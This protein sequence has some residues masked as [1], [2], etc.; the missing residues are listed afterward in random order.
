M[1]GDT[2]NMYD[3]QHNTGIVHNHAPAPALTPEQAEALAVVRS[4]AAALRGQLPEADRE[5]LDA[6]LA[7]LGEAA[8]GTDR[9]RTLFA[10]AGIAAT[11]GALGQP[12]LDSVRA[13]LEL[14][15][16]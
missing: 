10:I 13:A 5:A 8:A 15:G 16:A 7:G 6:G 1:S 2:V 9:R 4:L 11:V 14:F 12:L 3:G